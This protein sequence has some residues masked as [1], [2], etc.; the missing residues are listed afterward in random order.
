MVDDLWRQLPVFQFGNSS[1]RQYASPQMSVTGPWPMV[2]EVELVLEGGQRTVDG[3]FS[4]RVGTNANL[5][6]SHSRAGN[7][8]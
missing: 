6:D 4:N 3:G 5:T 2:G 8:N 7:Y 1:I